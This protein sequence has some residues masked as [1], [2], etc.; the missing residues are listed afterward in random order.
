MELEKC[1]LSEV[2][3]AQNDKRHMYF[4]MCTLASDLSFYILNLKYTGSQG[5]SKIELK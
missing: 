3:P 2:T 5:R 4:H 1:M